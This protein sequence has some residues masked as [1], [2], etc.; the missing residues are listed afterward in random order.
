MTLAGKEI[1]QFKFKGN[2]T[3]HLSDPKIKAKPISHSLS[4]K[5]KKYLSVY[6]PCTK[7]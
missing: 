2:S 5:V 1:N 7:K 6:F 3:V 4:W